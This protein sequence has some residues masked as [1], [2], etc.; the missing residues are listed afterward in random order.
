MSNSRLNKPKEIRATFKS[1]I[2]LCSIWVILTILYS[3]LYYKNPNQGFETGGLVAGGVA[4]LW[5]IWL[6]GFRLRVTKDYFE[7]RD[8]LFRSYKL[9]LNEIINVQTAWVEWKLITRKIRM[10]R[11]AVKARSEEK[12]VLIN[13]KP[14]NPKEISMVCNILKSEIKSLI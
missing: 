8:G 7:Y 10:P 2:I 5:I 9:H 12:S 11:I 3:L 13:P 4:L 1:Y 6:R 14:F